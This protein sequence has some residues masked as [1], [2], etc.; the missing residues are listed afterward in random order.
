MSAVVNQVVKQNSDKIDNILGELNKLKANQSPNIKVNI[1]DANS[2]SPKLTPSQQNAVANIIAQINT[3]S[4]SPQTKTLTLPSN[5]KKTTNSNPKKKTTK[6][7]KI[8]DM[9]ECSPSTVYYLCN[10]YQS[11]VIL[12]KPSEVWQ[13]ATAKS[14]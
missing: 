6:S 1:L 10:E 5:P 8:M 3:K 2:S 4:S 11:P 12:V 7:S 14:G 9:R 13:D